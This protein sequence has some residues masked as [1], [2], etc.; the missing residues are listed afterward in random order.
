MKAKHNCLD[1]PPNEYAAGKSCPKKLNRCWI[2]GATTSGCI[3]REKITC[4]DAEKS[5]ATSMHK[6]CYDMLRRAC[7]KDLFPVPPQG[8]IT[9]SYM[10]KLNSLAVMHLPHLFGQTETLKIVEDTDMYLNDPITLEDEYLRIAFSH[11]P[12]ELLQAAKT[13]L[14]KKRNELVEVMS[15]VRKVQDEEHYLF[16]EYQHL[17][18]IVCNNQMESFHEQNNAAVSIQRF[19]KGFKVRKEMKAK[20]DIVIKLQAVAR[21]F[22]VRRDFKS[23][24]TAHR[25][26]V[27]FAKDKKKREEDM[28]K[29]EKER[30]KQRKREQERKKQ[31]LQKEKEKK[32]KK[33]VEEREKKHKEKMER[34]QK[35]FEQDQAD[36]K[37]RQQQQNQNLY[38]K[39]GGAKR[40]FEGGQNEQNHKQFRDGSNPGMR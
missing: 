28:K 23:R 12:E 31:Q 15:L 22:L 36:K 2:C 29:K 32:M 20:K 30:E 18:E 1:P 7:P 11:K 37:K 8:K 24:L 4:N 13:K 34:R 17:Q 10:L 35:M 21:G 40:Q 14:L 26:K 19:W 39:N 5:K 6:V 9:C 3:V 16:S 33:E 38:R 27:K 25:A